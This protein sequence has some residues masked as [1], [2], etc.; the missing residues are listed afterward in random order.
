MEKLIKEQAK[1]IDR[2]IKAYGT[3]CRR[4]K[5]DVHPHCFSIK[6]NRIV[7]T[8]DHELCEVKADGVIILRNAACELARYKVTDTGRLR[9]FEP[10][11]EINSMTRSGLV[12]F[13]ERLT[14][15]EMGWLHSELTKVTALK[16]EGK[17]FPRYPNFVYRLSGEWEGWA[18]YL[19]TDTAGA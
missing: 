3:F 2:A 7:A 15:E 17:G 8:P 9:R 11:D 4:L 13:V 14:D 5:T 16:G 18:D 1:L 19:G 6:G 10:E 12:A